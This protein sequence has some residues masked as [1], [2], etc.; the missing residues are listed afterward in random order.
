MSMRC[1][2]TVLALTGIAFPLPL[3]AGDCPVNLTELG[4]WD[5]DTGDYGDVWGDGNIA[6]VAQYGDNGVHIIDI[7]NPNNPQELVEWVVQS[8]NTFASAQDVKVHDGLLFIALES[9]PNDGAEVVDVSQPGACDVDRSAADEPV[10][11]PV[12]RQRVPVH[13][14]QLDGAREHH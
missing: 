12:L 10:S 6:Y 7:S 9:D 11:Q 1:I 14:E 3:P 8:P 4:H 13:G 2:L 5:Q